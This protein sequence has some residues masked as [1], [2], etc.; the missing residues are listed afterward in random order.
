MYSIAKPRIDQGSLKCRANCDFFGNSKWEGF[1]SKCYREKGMKERLTAQGKKRKLEILLKPELVYNVNFQRNWT[2][3]YPKYRKE[4]LSLVTIPNRHL[5]TKTS[6]QKN[7]IFST[8][9]SKRRKF[10]HRRKV[11]RENRMC[12]IMLSGSWSQLL[13]LILKCWR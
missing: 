3:A 8:M 4:L 11:L 10:W 2:R 9:C 7:G 12:G 5:R 13:S 6:S 1:C